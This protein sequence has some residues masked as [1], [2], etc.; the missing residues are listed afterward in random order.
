MI[1]WQEK[2]EFD[3][4]VGVITRHPDAQIALDYANQAPNMDSV[5]HYFDLTLQQQRLVVLALELQ[6]G[7]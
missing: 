2:V 5:M 4:I 7:Y 6:Y 1:A 3:P